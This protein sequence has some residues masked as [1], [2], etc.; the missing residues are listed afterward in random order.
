MNNAT[1]WTLAED[2]QRRGKA[3]RPPLLVPSS[4]LLYLGV[5]SDLLLCASKGKM[6]CLACV[7]VGKHHVLLRGCI[8]AGGRLFHGRAPEL[9]PAWRAVLVRLLRKAGASVLGAENAKQSHEV[10]EGML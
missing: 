8:G 10:L 4:P 3:F 9:P 1:L 2:G 7:T 5:S 6:I